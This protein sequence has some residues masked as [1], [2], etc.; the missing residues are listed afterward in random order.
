MKIASGSTTNYLYFVAVD[1]T[2][3]KTRETGL[4]TF[5][6]YRSRNG[7]AAAAMTTPTINEV[8]ASNMP[9]VY[10]LLLD[11]DTTAT[12]EQEEMAFHITQASM[13]PVTRTVEIDKTGVDILALLANPSGIKKNTALTNFMFLM[14]DVTDHVTPITGETV[15]ATRSLDG[16]A[17]GACANAVAEVAS[18]MYKIDLAAADLN[19]DVVTLRFTAAGSDDRLITIVTEP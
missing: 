4:T 13:A 11:E 8:D 5:T 15:T 3:L 14:T 17:F 16:A 18:G 6:V 12:L 7:G 2:D 1:A 10:E 19:G 9:G